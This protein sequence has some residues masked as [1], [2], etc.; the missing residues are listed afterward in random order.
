MKGNEITLA[1]DQ[2]VDAEMYLSNKA[3]HRNESRG[4]SG[5]GSGEGYGGNSLVSPSP[6][7]AYDSYQ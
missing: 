5:R 1:L 2:S 4:G 7:V 6:R 3:N